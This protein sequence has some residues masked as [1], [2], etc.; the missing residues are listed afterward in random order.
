M[1]ACWRGGGEGGRAGVV[2]APARQAGLDSLWTTRE[3]ASIVA[4]NM[5]SDFDHFSQAVDYGAYPSYDACFWSANDAWVHDQWSQVGVV[6]LDPVIEA[7]STPAPISPEAIC[8]RAGVEMMLAAME[9]AQEPFTRE[10]VQLHGEQY[11]PRLDPASPHY[12]LV[13]CEERAVCEDDDFDP[14]YDSRL[15]PESDDYYLN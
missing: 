10:L 14:D 12:Y 9:C 8:I 13:C 7:W 2:K 5:Y 15:D 6:E 11:E 1:S 4:G 3:Y